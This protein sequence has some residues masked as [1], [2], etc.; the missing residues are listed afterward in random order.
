MRCRAVSSLSVVE[1]A[2]T[3]Y[4]RGLKLFE[5]IVGREIVAVYVV[6]EEF[7]ARARLDR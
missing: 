4:E 5:F 7:A 1:D 3:A 2:N 6:H